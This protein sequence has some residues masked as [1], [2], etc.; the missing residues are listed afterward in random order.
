MI[1]KEG[2]AQQLEERGKLMARGRGG[3]PAARGREGKVGCWRKGEGWSVTK[4]REKE[5]CGKKNKL[6]IKIKDN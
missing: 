4:V 3:E 6:E 1:V 5:K 2:G